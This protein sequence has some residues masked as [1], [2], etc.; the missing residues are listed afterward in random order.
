MILVLPGI[1]AL[2]FQELEQG[3]TKE[4]H[5][6]QGSTQIGG[7]GVDDC[8]YTWSHKGRDGRDSEGD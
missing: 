8:S 4:T 5:T 3:T 7:I 1:F 2:G 6:S